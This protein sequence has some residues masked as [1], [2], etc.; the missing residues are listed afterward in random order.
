MMKNLKM[1]WLVMSK[2]IWEIWQI[3]T[4]APESLK[5]YHFN[6]FLLSQVYI[7]WAKKVQ[8]KYLS[9]HW[10]V[11]QIWSIWLVVSKLAW[12]IWRILTQTL[13]SLKNL[14]FNELFLIKV[15][16]VWAKTVQRSYLSRNWKVIQNLRKNWLA[17]WKMTKEIW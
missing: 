9:W 4:H 11:I 17:V 12:W 10:K 16:K 15:F 8:R 2:L 14:H 3:L 13:G 6:E 5:N 7:V 1:N